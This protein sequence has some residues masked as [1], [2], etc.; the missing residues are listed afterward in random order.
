MNREREETHALSTKTH[1]QNIGNKTTT[2]RLKIYI[3]R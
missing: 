3:I 2:H 1:T